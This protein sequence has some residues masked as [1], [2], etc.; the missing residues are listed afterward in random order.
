MRTGSF[1]GDCAC[2]VQN[3]T[4]ITL[5]TS[6]TG[7][8]PGQGAGAAAHEAGFAI[9][10]ET[11]DTWNYL[12]FD[13]T[14]TSAPD[15]L[16]LLLEV[17]LGAEVIPLWEI[18]STA[19]TTNVTHNSG[20]INISNISGQPVTFNL[21]LSSDSEGASA[22]VTN[23]RFFES[24]NA[25]NQVPTAN[26]GPDQTLVPDSNGISLV[27]LDG[28]G[29]TDPEKDPLVYLWYLNEQ[30]VAFDNPATIELNRGSHL[31]TVL[32][33]DVAD[34]KDVDEILITVGGGIFI[35]GDANA[36]SLIEISDALAALLVLF[37]EN[38]HFHEGV[39]AE[40]DV[41]IVVAEWQRVS[42]LPIQG[43]FVSS[44][45]RCSLHG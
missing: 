45:R 44:S 17:E 22:V 3:S 30:L 37:G 7:A 12:S 6:T 27:V 20:V 40:F 8:G 14:F 42:C 33:R 35:R 41:W 43:L 38:T 28:S 2:E 13:Y 21:I 16:V 19:I 26:A 9:P 36:D 18:A 34:N 39:D 24:S 23:L 31:I 29:S 11:L 15:L 5:R 1:S 4:S 25:S 32:V 10:L